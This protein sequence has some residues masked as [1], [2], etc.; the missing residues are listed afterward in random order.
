M[1][2]LNYEWQNITS[3]TVYRANGSVTFW[4]DAKI[5]RQDIN[6]NYSVIDTRL[7]ST[8]VNPIS[9]TGY[10]FKLTGSSGRSGSDVWTFANETILTGQYTDYHNQDGSKTTY[11][12][13]YVFNNYWNIE[14]TFGVWVASPTIPRSATI[15]GANNFT[16]EENAVFTFTNKANFQTMPYLKFYID[17]TLIK[18]ITREKSSYTSPYTLELTNTER[19][20]LRTL[21]TA[22]TR[23]NVKYGLETYNQSTY[24]GNYE[25]QDRIFSIVN[26][27]PIFS[28]FEFEDVNSTTLALTGNNKI[29][30][31]GY[32]NIQVTIS[33][34]NKAIAQKNATMSKYTFINSDLVPV[35]IAYS[36]SEAVSGTLEK[37]RNGKYEVYA[38][39]SRGNTT[40]V[41]KLATSVEAY[42][43]IYINKQTSGV[44]RD[45]NGVGSGAILTLEG[46]IW[47]NNFG[48]VTNSIKSVTYRLKKTNES[49]WAT[50]TTTITPTISNNTFSFQG[51]IA[52]DN[53]DTSWTLDSTFDI[54]ITITDELSSSTIN[55]TL[56]S[57]IPTMSIDKEGV[58]ILCAYDRELGG[59]LQVKGERIDGYNVETDGVAVKTGRR[60]DDKEE[61]VK[62]ITCSNLG[63][64]GQDR[65]YPT[66]I[67]AINSIITDIKI[68]GHSSLNNWFPLPNNDN[69]SSKVALMSNGSLRITFFNNNWQ[70]ETAYAE[71]YYI[72]NT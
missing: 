17:N 15:T 14:N 8:V 16:D 20:E 67:D 13:A 44:V 9:G 68:L 12:E 46:T 63:S 41:T 3:W 60:I 40:L 35:E 62:R 57:S 27:D 50:G 37:T 7:T 42:E 53:Q 1:L 26:A 4:I 24:I 70:G 28:D 33:T 30:I 45:N 31:N 71:I 23:C 54:E 6:G 66:G 38:E 22:K 58:G 11:I 36:D 49:S 21:L 18:T 48:L 51:L 19:E 25:T 43:N 10:N 69:S 32:S 5:N 47:N 55:L 2:T 29:N 34:S 64:S 61:Y 59:M 72:E 56:G 39:D 65:D 52:G